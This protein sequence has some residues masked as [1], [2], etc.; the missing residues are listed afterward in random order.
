MSEKPVIIIGN[1]GHAKVLV[2]TLLLHN[3]KIIG[4]TA[5][6][7]EHNPYSLSYIGDDNAIL[8]F[9]PSEVELVNAIGSVSDTSLR[10]KLFNEFKSQ[11]Y[12]FSLVIH[13]SAIISPTVKLGEGVQIMAGVVIQ[14]FAK[15]ADNTIVN[16]STTIDH[17]C[18]IGEHCHLAPGVTMSGGVI[19]DDGTHIGTGTNIIQNIYIGKKVLV[20]SGSLVIKDVPNNKVVFGTPAKEVI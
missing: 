10:E 19:V 5:P 1:G 9:H 4:F 3:R 12:F 17:D 16:T 6:E 13:P 20:G 18:K 11:G 15:I 2:E 14:P 8:E 7:I